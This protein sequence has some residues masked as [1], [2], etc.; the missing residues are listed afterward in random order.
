[1]GMS[2]FGKRGGISGGRPSFVFA[3]PMK[4]GSGPA[5]PSP[6]EGGD[7]FPPIDDLDPI[8]EAPAS[9]GGVAPGAAMDRLT[10]RQNASGD[11][12]SSD[13]QQG[14]ARRGIP[15]D[16]FGGAD[17]AQ[18]QPQPARAVRARKGAGR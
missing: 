6:L 9:D 12:G 8:A 3:K 13:A 18:D 14:R 1:M 11:Q 15:P 7:Q 4:G 16:H 10:A 2:A 5:S 17:R